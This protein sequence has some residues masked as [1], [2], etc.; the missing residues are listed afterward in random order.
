MSAAS[1]LRPD[2]HAGIPKI[3]GDSSLALLAEGYTFGHRRFQHFGTDVFRTRLMAKPVTVLRGHEA[4]RFFYEGE[5]FNR[6]GA[7][8]RSVLHSLQDEGSVQTLTGG[9]HRTRKSLF[10]DILTGPT[11]ADLEQCFIDEW[12]ATQTRW[13]PGADVSLFPVVEQILT[14]SVLRWLGLDETPKQRHSLARQCSAMID[15]AGSFGPRNW[16]GRVLRLF[17]ERWARD[18]VR[19]VRSG[20]IVGLPPLQVLAKEAPLEEGV[21]AVELINLLRPTVAT[22]RFVVFAALALHHYPEWRGRVLNDPDAGRQFAQEVRRTTPFFPVIAG[23]AIG[24]HEWQGV[25]FRH[26]DWVMVDL[27]ATNRHPR[28]WQ[29]AGTFDPSRFRTET[30]ANTARPAA[31][32]SAVIDSRV[33][34]QG[35]GM[36][37]TSHR[38]PGEPA[39]IDMLATAVRQLAS[40]EWSIPDQD[41]SVDLSR[42]P[43]QPGSSSLRIVIAG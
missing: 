27:F 40:F 17:T 30:S 28:E 39:T 20:E 35:A 6:Q 26:D 36:I 1:T 11:G 10:V 15:G 41:L 29:D 12:Q 9:A 25:S 33:V 5:R 4:A 16:R 31:D 13:Q 21:A 2:S 38:C 34:A 22:A 24:D 43:A 37:E 18:V 32:D 14:D 42:I 23:R 19:S 7:M 3:P 8:P